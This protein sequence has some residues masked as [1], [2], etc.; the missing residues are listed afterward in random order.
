[1]LDLQYPIQQKLVV[2]KLLRIIH[3][4]ELNGMADGTVLFNSN[5]LETDT[6]TINYYYNPPLK[7][8]PP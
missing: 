3:H 2:I 6:C 7:M 4:L 1:M 5:S 8:P